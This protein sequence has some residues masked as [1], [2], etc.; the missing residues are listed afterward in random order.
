MTI[1]PRQNFFFE[2]RPFPFQCTDRPQPLPRESTPG[3]V[4]PIWRRTPGPGRDPGPSARTGSRAHHSV[5]ADELPPHRR[6]KSRCLGVHFCAIGEGD[7]EPEARQFL[8]Q[9]SMNQT[10]ASSA[11]MPHIRKNRQPRRSACT[12]PPGRAADNTCNRR[13]RTPEHERPGAD[14][15]CRWTRNHSKHHRHSR[16]RGRGRRFRRCAWACNA[17]LLLGD[18]FEANRPRFLG[19]LSAYAQRE[20]RVLVPHGFESPIEVM[21]DRKRILSA[22]RTSVP[23]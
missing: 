21:V 6:G 17:H 11:S 4:R 3:L 23:R 9:V 20:V 1:N 5:R 18:R 14:L 16:C 2:R 10:A 8:D 7:S 12:G 13:S 19:N 15:S 22:G